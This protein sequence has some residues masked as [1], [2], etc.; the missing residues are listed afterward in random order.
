MI[1]FF[2]KLKKQHIPRIIVNDKNNVNCEKLI[3]PRQILV[4]VASHRRLLIITNFIFHIEE[5]LVLM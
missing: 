5:K 4:K 2:L 1:F 3:M